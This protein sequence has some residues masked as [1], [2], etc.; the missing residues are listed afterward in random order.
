MKIWVWEPESSVDKHSLKDFSVKLISAVV[1]D[2]SLETSRFEQVKCVDAF[3]MFL[4]AIFCLRDSGPGF[5]D[6]ERLDFG[7]AT[8]SSI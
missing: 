3:A 5:L 6:I 8:F 2:F 1:L 7:V 4:S